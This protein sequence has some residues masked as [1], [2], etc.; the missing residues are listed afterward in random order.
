MTVGPAE[1]LTRRLYSA[2]A[3]GWAL[4][5]YG[6]S[7][8]SQ[9]TVRDL[10]SPW[11]VVGDG[12][13]SRWRTLTRW[14]G[15][16]ARRELFKRLPLLAPQRPRELAAAAAAVLSAFAVPAPDPPPMTVLA[17]HGAVHAG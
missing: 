6:L 3:I 7:L 1:M 14:C 9:S 4:A 16:T 10:V 12:S 11:R 8:L 17:F 5:L 2:C 13:I 15:A